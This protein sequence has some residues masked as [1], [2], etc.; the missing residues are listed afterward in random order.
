MGHHCN[1]RPFAFYAAILS[2]PSHSGSWE[3]LLAFSLYKPHWVPGG[4]I[5]PRSCKHESFRRCSHGAISTLSLQR[6]VRSIP[7]FTVITVFYSMHIH[8]SHIC[9]LN[10]QRWAVLKSKNYVSAC[11]DVFFP[12]LVSNQKVQPLFTSN[13]H[14]MC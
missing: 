4:S 1:P 12:L 8:G 5:L 6:L 11:T 2:F 13:L 10:Y 3:S 9:R 14:C 7:P